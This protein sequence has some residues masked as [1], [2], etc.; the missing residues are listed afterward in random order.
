MLST[1]PELPVKKFGSRI[2]MGLP[3]WPSGK[4]YACQCRW[5]DAGDVGSIPESGRS[6]GVRNGNPHKYSCLGNPMDRGSWRE[7]VHGSQR[8]GH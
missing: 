2:K 6:P 1:R 3:R 5:G 7:I 4:E 8:V